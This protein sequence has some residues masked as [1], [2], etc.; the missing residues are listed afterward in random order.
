MKLTKIVGLV[1]SIAS[2]IG[3][4]VTAPSS[5]SRLTNVIWVVFFLFFATL[6]ASAFRRQRQSLQE[7]RRQ[8]DSKKE[9]LSALQAEHDALTTVERKVGAIAAK[10]P[11]TST[12]QGEMKGFLLSGL[13]ILEELRSWN[14][15]TFPR[16][17]TLA[18]QAMA[19]H[20]SRYGTDSL[21]ANRELLES[22][23]ALHVLLQGFRVSRQLDHRD[24]TI[25]R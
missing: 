6:L 11:V 15:E 7:T 9:D 13:A 21:A 25:A 16:A 8:L 18:D 3:P 10:C 12:S 20:D 5:S 17:V 24:G 1:G 23:K 19:T 22:C 14:P 2:I 4:V